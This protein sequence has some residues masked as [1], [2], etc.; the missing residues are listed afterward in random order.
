M[1]ISI[2]ESEI[3]QNLALPIPFVR[4]FPL[5]LWENPLAPFGHPSLIRLRLRFGLGLPSPHED[6]FS[7][8]PLS[9]AL[10]GVVHISAH[11]PPMGFLAP[12]SRMET[13]G[14]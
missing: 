1:K 5:S 14:P 8:P 7:P 12:C 10:C 3:A 13:G 2:D 11:C 9:F 6:A 4:I